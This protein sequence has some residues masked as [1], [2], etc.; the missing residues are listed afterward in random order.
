VDSIVLEAPPDADL[1]HAELTRGLQVD[2]TVVVLME[3]AGREP[4]D[5]QAELQDAQV[6]LQDAQVQPVQWQTPAGREGHLERMV[7]AWELALELAAVARRPLAARA[8]ELAVRAAR[9]AE[10]AARAA[11]AA[12]ATALLVMPVAAGTVGAAKRERGRLYQ[13]EKL[14]EALRGPPFFD[15]NA[16]TAHF[17]VT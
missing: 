2:T 15:L 7:P 4:T 12:L 14:K 17:L 3:R 9:A 6:Q 13:V 16:S 5:A 11:R 1:V 10:L 8:A